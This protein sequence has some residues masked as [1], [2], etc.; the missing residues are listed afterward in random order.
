MAKVRTSANP[1]LISANFKLLKQTRVKTTTIEVDSGVTR[2]AHQDYSYKLIEADAFTK[3][4]HADGMLGIIFN[5]TPNGCKL[6]MYLLLKINKN[7]DTVILDALIVA[8][9]IDFATKSI[10]C[11]IDR[12]YRHGHYLQEV[13]QNVL[14][15]SIIVF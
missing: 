10:L 7:M 5:L 14:D 4:Y 6:F 8:P 2:V 3:F 1:F 9:A 11:C 13:C 15:K 12:H